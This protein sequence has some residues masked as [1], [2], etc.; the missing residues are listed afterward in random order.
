MKHKGTKVSKAL[1]PDEGALREAEFNEQHG[2]KT[3]VELLDAS[4]TAVNGNIVT[5]QGTVQGEKI[6]KP[7]KV[8]KPKAEKKLV[9]LTPWAHRENSMA[10]EIDLALINGGFNFNEMANK[11]FQKYPAFDRLGKNTR[12]LDGVKGKIRSHC[13]PYLQR[14]RGIIVS[15]DADGFC[16]AEATNYAS[17]GNHHTRPGVAV[18]TPA[19]VLALTMSPEALAKRQAREI[20]KATKAQAKADAKVAKALAKATAKAERV[21]VE[22]PLTPDAP[23]IAPDV[24][25]D[26]AQVHAA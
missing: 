6:E 3:P 23:A 26:Q 15:I 2:I 20:E 14:E 18:Q 12:T 11:L 9:A 4:L 1:P 22:T 5:N 13:W 21:K 7:A 10:G 25:N 17:T 8:K 24:Q 19:E 16:T